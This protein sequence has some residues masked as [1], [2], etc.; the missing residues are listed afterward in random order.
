MSAPDSSSDSDSDSDW[1][2]IDDDDEYDIAQVVKRRRLAHS[3][4]STR[5]KSG[6]STCIVSLRGISRRVIASTK[7]LLSIYS[8]S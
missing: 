6:P 1:S 8:G 3:A 7:S 2:D 5:Q 4:A